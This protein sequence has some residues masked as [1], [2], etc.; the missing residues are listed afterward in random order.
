MTYPQAKSNSLNTCAWNILH[1]QKKGI[2]PVGVCPF[3]VPQAFCLFFFYKKYGAI[4]SARVRCVPNHFGSQDMQ[5][6]PLPQHSLHLP[7]R[8]CAVLV[9]HRH[10]PV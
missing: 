5:F 3:F 6:Y 8:Q 1:H 10:T 2:F 7:T 9:V 4:L